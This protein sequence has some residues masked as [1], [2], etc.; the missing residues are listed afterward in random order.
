MF[1]KF[2]ISLKSLAILLA[3][4]CSLSLVKSVYADDYA[5][6]T[7]K[8]NF[9]PKEKDKEEKVP[10]HSGGEKAKEGNATK[11]TKLPQTGSLDRNFLSFVLLGILNIG[12]FVKIL[13]VEE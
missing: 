5:S 9:I 12:F 2:V 10:V 8:I 11:N 4:I 1:R 3:L 13:K 7:T 6:G